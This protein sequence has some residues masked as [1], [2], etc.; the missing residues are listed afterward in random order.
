VA[1]GQITGRVTG[2]GSALPGVMVEAHNTGTG[3]TRSAMTE[4][5]GSYS[6]NLLPPGMYD[7]KG[8][9]SGFRGATRQ[10]VRVTISE[11]TTID[12]DLSLEASERITV[13][14]AAPVVETTSA[15]ISQ[16]VD[17]TEIEN[18][19]L[20]G[21]DF[22]DLIQLT[23][24]AVDAGDG[25]VA[26]G[27]NRG[28]NNS[29]NIDGA[30]SNS[31]FFGEERG[32]TR[33]AFTFSQAAIREFRVLSSSYDAQF[34]NATGGIINAITKSGTNTVQGSLFYFFRDQG[35]V[36]DDALGRKPRNFDQKQGGLTAGGPIITDRLHFFT[37]YD[38][39]RK[40]IDT[41]RTFADPAGALAIPANRARLETLLGHP[42]AEELDI[43]QSDDMDTLLL[44]L[45][46]QLGG[47]HLLSM[48]DNW[49][50]YQGQNQTN[51]FDTSWLSTNGLEENTFNSLVGSLNSVLSA[52]TYNEVIFQFSNE[53]RPRGANNTTLPEIQ[54]GN[55][56]DATFGQNNFLPNNLE[57]SRL[58]LTDNFTRQ[59]NQH[60]LKSG[61]DV[62]RLE[63][64]DLFFRFQA[65]QY[66][67]N[68]WTDFFNDRPAQYTQAFS[69][70][71]GQV[72]Y[73]S[74]LM[75][76]Y[77]QDE[78]K[79]NNKLTVNGGLRYELQRNPE[80]TKNPAFPQTGKI[81][82]DTNN[83]APR[84]G[85]AYDLSGNGKS[86]LRGGV[87][88]FFNTTPSLLIANALLTNG[89]TVTRVNV[90]RAAN[91][92]LPAG[93]PTFPNRIPNLGSLPAVRPDLFVVQPDFQ[94]PETWRTSIGY[95]RELF[96]NFSGSV[97]L[98]YAKGKHFER[99]WDINL[100]PA[101]ARTADG[102]PLYTSSARPFTNFNRIIQFTSDA[103]T[104]YRA[105]ILSFQ[106]R[107]TTRW[108]FTANYTY[109][110]AKDH[111]TNERNVS[112][113]GNVPMDMFDIDSAWGP[114][115]YDVR[116]NVVLSGTVLLPWDI[117]FSTIGNWRS[118]RPW[119]ALDARDL[120]GDAMFV[121]R[122]VINGQIVGR[123]SFRQPNYKN[124]DLRISKQFH[125]LGHSLEFLAEGFNITDEANRTTSRVTY[126]TSSG[127]LRSD[128][129]TLNFVTLFPRQFQIGLK[130]E[131]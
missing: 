78:W 109:A 26:V 113:S 25:R 122:P 114:S 86:V 119:T 61:F 9:L 94:N 34:G 31:N 116:H 4:A 91:G 40:T 12:L 81:P 45:D 95:E 93:F 14:A 48:R 2:A 28:I 121:D 79:P 66:I 13:T 59:F 100:R 82:D 63:Y 75:S 117:R 90:R 6:I 107:F 65:G 30:D 49:S 104:D 87:G 76:A 126:N 27:G 5:D 108:Q 8:A 80:P 123:N 84:V 102:R 43:V 64:K 37:A 15:N 89:V 50:S 106:R 22:K 38:G 130:F 99:R 33:P 125:L 103:E 115:D 36:S 3:L 101:T 20:N 35:F 69:P 47:N 118:G 16:I 10:N 68:N 18:L 42:L 52:K 57:E 71:G 128:F 21:R 29:F 1:T 7:V 110:N 55:N 46:W 24:G 85:L 120:N 60:T 41:P 74:S 39:Q 11:S 98:V 19:P 105:A 97:D 88:R 131:Y 62:Q 111:D 32:G 83:F 73:D 23:P 51:T 77:V 127:A 53:D 112:S 129:G 67:F 72:N 124:L 92:T 58:Q 70:V 96:P 54:I 17:Q 44:K 56:F